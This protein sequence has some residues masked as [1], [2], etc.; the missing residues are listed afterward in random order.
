MSDF[1]A[2]LFEPADNALRRVALPDGE[3]FHAAAVDLIGAT[4]TASFYL[5]PDTL[6]FVDPDAAR[7]DNPALWIVR[8]SRTLPYAGRAILAGYAGARR[9]TTPPESPTRL[10]AMLQ[11]LGCF[12]PPATPPALVVPLRGRAS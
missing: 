10:A 2:Y 7:R 5:T 11:V 9:L 8:T 12:T 1:I 3:G 4:G 6:A